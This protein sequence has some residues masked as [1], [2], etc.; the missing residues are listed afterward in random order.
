MRA[1][2]MPKVR[3]KDP[4]E[5]SLMQ[6]R[7]RVLT[8]ERPSEAAAFFNGQISAKN[9][10]AGDRY[11]LSLAYLRMG[12]YAKAT[13]ALKPVLAELPRQANLVLLQARIQMS[14]GETEAALANLARNLDYFPRYAPAILEYADQLITAGKPDAARQ[15]LLSH[16]QAL[17][18]R[19]DTY[20]LLAYAARDAGQTSEAQYQ[21]ANYLFERGDAL[22]ALAQLDAAL[23][24]SSLSAQ[25]R[26]RFQAR[27]AEIAQN[28][29]ERPPQGQQPRQSGDR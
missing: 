13:D 16:E 26:S 3:V 2:A 1:A 5:F 8:S 20:R 28:A 24:V 12:E 17:G 27:R 9:A 4:V 21:M 11:G 23:R 10:T 6:A 15:V 7:A 25:E 22:G 19:M 14:Q 29:P 18:T